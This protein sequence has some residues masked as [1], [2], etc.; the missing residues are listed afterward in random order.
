MG[1]DFH[2]DEDNFLEQEGKRQHECRLQEL[3]YKAPVRLPLRQDLPE[4]PGPFHS[5]ET[6]AQRKSKIFAM[7]APGELI[8]PETGKI[9]GRP[10]T[11]V[12]VRLW[13]FS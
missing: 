12:S 7:Q 8:K 1:W 5:C 3:R 10:K 4:L 11:R 6:Q 9:R 13:L 2:N